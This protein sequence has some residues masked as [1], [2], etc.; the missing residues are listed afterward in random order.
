LQINGTG[1]HYADASPHATTMVSSTDALHN[2]G[3]PSM[4]APVFGPDS[5]LARFLLNRL[6]T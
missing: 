6:L 2:R 1:L 4:R 3:K 5:A